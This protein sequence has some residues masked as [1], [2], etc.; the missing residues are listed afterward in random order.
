[1]IKKIPM[2]SLSVIILFIG[3]CAQITYAQLGTVSAPRPVFPA[4]EQVV[5]H[6]FPTFSWM[7]MYPQKYTAT[8]EFKLVETM[9]GQSPQAAIQANP[10]LITK[11]YLRLPTFTYPASA[12]ALAKGKAYAWQVTATYYVGVNE[13]SVPRK[14]ASEVY[15]FQ[16]EKPRPTTCITLL[17]E[18]PD[19]QQ[20][21]VVNDYKLRFNLAAQNHQEVRALQFTIANK[22]GESITNHRIVPVKAKDA[23]G[24]YIIPLRK[25]AAFRKK[26]TRNQVYVLKVNTPEGKTFQVNFTAK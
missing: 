24:Q 19:S 23:E 25:Y 18:Q 16:L 8:Y 15:S 9:K 13:S 20:F 4:K 2:R 11:K 7:P 10:P 1:M 14:L 6:T 21:Y 17:T 5:Q 26:R 3:L 12:P 22:Q